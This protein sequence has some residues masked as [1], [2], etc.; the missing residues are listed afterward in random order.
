M[1]KFI[2][3]IL[4]VF[5]IGLASSAYAQ[6]AARASGFVFEITDNEGVVTTV[7]SGASADFMPNGL[8][9]LIDVHVVLK[10]ESD[11]I[12]ETPTA[13]YD[14]GNGIINSNEAISLKSDTM[15]I[16][17]DG[18]KWFADSGDIYIKHNADIEVVNPEGEPTKVSCVGYLHIQEG[19]AFL[20]KDVVIDASN[21]KV[22]GDK[23]IIHFE[24]GEEGVVGSIKQME[25]EGENMLIVSGGTDIRGKKGLFVFSDTDNA[26]GARDIEKMTIDQDVIIMFEDKVA[27]GQKAE[28]TAA[29]DLLILSGYPKIKEGKNTY[30]AEK[31]KIYPKQDI[32]E[33]EPQA[34]LIVEG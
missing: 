5:F 24:E 26:T 17:G 11:T 18:A 8:I 21:T 32:V 12:I 9:R 1:F 20:H 34:E 16:T 30:A 25:V 33:F 19:V 7:V 2:K 27:T 15:N 13:F 10:G 22:Q 28:Y 29:D 31:I 6:D 23:A 14:R 3:I 4:V